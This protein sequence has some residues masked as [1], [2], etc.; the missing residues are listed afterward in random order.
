MNY[1]INSPQGVKTYNIEQQSCSEL[2]H[3]RE[4]QL[5]SA[6]QSLKQLPFIEFDPDGVKITS[7]WHPP[8]DSYDAG[9][10]YADDMAIIFSYLEQNGV[11]TGTLFQGIIASAMNESPT[12][13]ATGFITG[14][15]MRYM[16]Q[17]I[18][19]NILPLVL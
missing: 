11:D 5:F 15:G 9:L 10:K 2:I 12:D 13:T 7:F 1:S 6:M 8:I 18:T 4:A 19:H 14:I 16:G 17:R 3:D